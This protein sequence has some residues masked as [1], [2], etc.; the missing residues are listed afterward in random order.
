[1]IIMELK[2][3]IID[4]MEA[5]KEVRKRFDAIKGLVVTMYDDDKFI[6]HLREMGANG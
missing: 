3:P 4:G 5:T 6:I 2:M 1:M